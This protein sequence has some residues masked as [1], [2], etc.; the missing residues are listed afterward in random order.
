MLFWRAP[1]HQKGWAKSLW[2]PGLGLLWLHQARSTAGWSGRVKISHAVIPHGFWIIGSGIWWPE[3]NHFLQQ[4]RILSFC[5][6]VLKCKKTKEFI[7]IIGVE[8][9]DTALSVKLRVQVSWMVHLSAECVVKHRPSRIRQFVKRCWLPKDSLWLF[10]QEQH[11]IS[12]S[13]QKQGTWTLNRA[14]ESAQPK[15]KIGEEF[16]L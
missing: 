7:P 11:G 4:E 3:R 13:R 10:L 14:A 1:G 5:R 9:G 2:N 12:V 16:V 8:E 15:C 6:Y